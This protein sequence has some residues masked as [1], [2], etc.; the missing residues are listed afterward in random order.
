MSTSKSSEDFLGELDL[1]QE[2]FATLRGVSRQYAMRTIN[3]FLQNPDEINKFCRTLLVI[4][5]DRSRAMAEKLKKY[6][7]SKLGITVSVG[8]SVLFADINVKPY[9]QLFAESKELWIW[10]ASPL[11]IEY[12]GYWGKLCSEFLDYE[13]RMLVYFVPK[14]EIADQLIFRFETE[15]FSRL[16]DVEGKKQQDAKGFGATIFIIVTNL[17]AMVP[18]MV[19]ANPGSANLR[20]EGLN[21]SGWT[22]GDKAQDMYEISSRFKDQLIQQVRASGLGLARAPENFFPIG[23]PLKNGSGVPFKNY[24]YL[25][26]LIAI[27]NS[28][29]I[30][31][32]DGK[33]E[34]RTDE[35]AMSSAS[36]SEMT[37]NEDDPPETPLKL[38]P[39]FVR[40]Y[41]KKSGELTTKIDPPTAKKRSI[42]NR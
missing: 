11:E 17:A 22:I 30:G 28:N 27:R 16:Y 15:L 33:P 19:I 10:A 37:T 21:S 40:A 9:G 4:G 6:A 3:D 32:F 2:E 7:A 34:K 18:Y 5:S 29:S 36:S 25:D 13:N 14:L 23:E 42:F 26:H 31:L 39:V 1:K 8:T 20:Q 41:R 38:Y 12:P 35:D 24:R